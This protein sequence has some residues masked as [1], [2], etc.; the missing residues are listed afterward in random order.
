MHDNI[1]KA[2]NLFSHSLRLPE[3]SFEVVKNYNVDASAETKKKWVDDGIFNFIEIYR[4][5]SKLIDLVEQ[6]DTY[7]DEKNQFVY[8][9]KAILDDFAYHASIFGLYFFNIDELLSNR[10]KEN[11]VIKIDE[12]NLNLTKNDDENLNNISRNFESEMSHD[13]KVEFLK[14]ILLSCRKIK[15]HFDNTFKNKN[16]QAIA[17][18]NYHQLLLGLYS[19]ILFL[20]Y[21]WSIWK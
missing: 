7:P 1:V 18:S 17:D 15:A 9:I 8:D 5:V 10:Q 16:E 14:K 12:K 21:S 19:E 2:F 3:S 6:F 13:Q 20:Q 4:S 11:D